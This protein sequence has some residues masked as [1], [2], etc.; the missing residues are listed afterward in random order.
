MEGD[1][2]LDDDYNG[3]VVAEETECI[4]C[5]FSWPRHATNQIRREEEEDGRGEPMLVSMI[6]I[7]VIYEVTMM[8]LATLLAISVQRCGYILREVRPGE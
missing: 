1:L 7:V 5:K 8:C 2:N 4:I 6:S 3:I